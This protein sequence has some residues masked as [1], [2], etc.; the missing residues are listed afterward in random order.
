MAA[1]SAGSSSRPCAV[2]SVTI[3]VQYSV[4]G[5][6]DEALTTCPGLACALGSYGIALLIVPDEQPN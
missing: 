1:S 4:L 3:F 2:R 5:G 6:W